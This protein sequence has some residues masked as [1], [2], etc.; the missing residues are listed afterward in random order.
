MA[1]RLYESF[2]KTGKFRGSNLNFFRPPIGSKLA[3]MHNSRS[4]FRVQKTAL[5]AVATGCLALGFASPIQAAETADGVTESDLGYCPRPEPDVVADGVDDIEAE[6]TA[7]AT[8]PVGEVLSADSVPL[9]EEP[10][11][12]AL[13]V[14]TFNAG[15]SRDASGA[16]LE[17]L[18]A[19]GAEDAS[20]VARVIQTVRPD[21]LVLTGID[22]DSGDQIA[23]AF[24]T[25]YLA[26]GGEDLEGIS[27]SYSY[28][29]ETN[30]GVD[31]G[32]DLDRD[33][34]IG[35]PADALGYGDFPGQSAMIVYS[36]HPIETGQLRDFSS[37]P[38]KSMPDNSIPDD[39][40]DLERN[41][42]PLSSVAHW[43]IPIEVHGEVLHVLASAAAEATQA[44]YGQARNDDQIRFWQDYL[45]ADT[46]Y[47]LDHRGD[48]GPLAE[49]AAFVIAGSLKADPEGHGPAQP[50]A[51][52]QLLA[53][54]NIV[55]PQQEHTL[56][57]HAMGPGVLPN[58]PEAEYHTA[59]DPTDS[60]LTYR[61]DYVL[62]GS[63]LTVTN[64][65][66]LETGTGRNDVYRGYFDI[67]SN[68]TTSHMVWADLVV[69]E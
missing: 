41:I 23:D 62:P 15:L 43:D 28:T 6:G 1:M 8:A 51:I 36:K 14:A 35:G 30:A 5:I 63:N 50:D 26:V 68:T 56:P 27:Y 45:E 10:A 38:W 46:D 47:I 39:F 33:G 29:A 21:V 31:S 44:P 49:D 24:N 52:S 61:A 37:L 40:T 59:P 57:P 9:L 53:S 42:L 54:E 22:T 60:S 34:M 4:V 67:Q 16:L 58:K 25:N 69:D 64:S 19:P 66:I 48:R 55:D 3:V 2:S 20:E 17:E 65:G 32:A 13:R 18:S 11:T 12:E 7:A